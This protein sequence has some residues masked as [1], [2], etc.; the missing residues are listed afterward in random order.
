MATIPT[1]LPL[2]VPAR[3]PVDFASR[4]CP[5]TGLRVHLAAERLIIA[6]AVAAVVFLLVGGLMALP[7]VLTRWPAVGLLSA[8][9]EL[10]YRVLTLHG[11]NMLLFWII[12]FEVA[13]LYFGGAVVL[14]ARLVNPP[15]AWA[16]FALMLGGALLTEAVVL[17]G[18]A[19]VLFTS[20]VPL[21]AHPLFYLGVILF[22]VG[23]VVA[24]GLY[25]A[26]VIVAKAEGRY[27]GSQPLVTFGLTTAAIIATFTLVGGVL[28]YLPTFFWSLGLAELD[29]EVY[30][31]NF[32]SIGHASQQI[33][34]AA[35]VSV[36]YLLAAITV[37]ARVLNEKLSR[38]AFLLY[39]LFINLGSV[40]HLLVDPGVSIPFRVVNTSYLLYLA[41]LGSLIHAFSIP[42]GI[43]ITQ[44]A[45]GYTRGLFE[46]LRKAPWREPG[47]SSLVLSM[48]LFGF[49]GGT[50]GVTLGHEQ[51]NLVWH[52]TLAVPGHFH[53][54]V[55]AGTTLAF[56]GLT[57][58]VIPLIARRELVGRR[59]AALQP[60]VFALGVTLLSLGM[61]AAGAL[62]VPR[63][64]SDLSYAGAAVPVAFPDSAYLAL[65]VV[66][67][68][69]LIAAVGGAM[70]IGVAVASL[71]LGRVIPASQQPVLVPAAPPAAALAVEHRVPGTLVL[72]F[73]F[74]A[75]FALVVA[76]NYLRL[77]SLWPVR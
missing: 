68:G 38:F 55:V 20:Y 40:H 34:L 75:F 32:W 37:G 41:V 43:E 49:L 66:G 25:F 7:V 26:T 46:W 9:P 42:A 35:M 14:N 61:M 47:F 5:V 59:L 63:R 31:L 74:L 51:I 64:V 50:T 57:Y 39:I 30:R 19:D 73:G 62:G 24:V 71:L 53:A 65:G 13:G 28:T 18:Q 23:A 45:K 44:R 70:Y 76:G 69:G 60:Y 56:M 1:A 2:P 21:R 33:N 52:N 12:F 8:V 36:W 77:S 22:A 48:V 6:N 16:A 4:I 54:T 67:I 17:L 10:Y 15:L 58:Y 11:L 3:Q 27:T 72:T 29:A